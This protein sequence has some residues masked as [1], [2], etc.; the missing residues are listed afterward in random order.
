[1]GVR[2][3]KRKESHDVSRVYP[4]KTVNIPSF[5]YRYHSKQQPAFNLKK[6]KMPTSRAR[7]GLPA[8]FYRGWV[9]Y[10]VACWKDRTPSVPPL[11]SNSRDSCSRRA[12]PQGWEGSRHAAKSM[13]S[14]TCIK[15]NIIIVSCSLNN[16]QATFAWFK[17]WLRKHITVSANK[18]FEKCLIL[19]SL[20]QWIT[21][22]KATYFIIPT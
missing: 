15:I 19:R 6:H 13:T 11:Q 7:G 4:V 12:F 10:R 20:S 8:A 5:F 17:S 3:G 21:Q 22:S 18:R 14:H 16:Y 9:R 2:R 1:M